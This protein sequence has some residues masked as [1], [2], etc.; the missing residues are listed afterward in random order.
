MK[1]SILGGIRRTLNY[2]HFTLLKQLK[3]KLRPSPTQFSIGSCLTHLYGCKRYHHQNQLSQIPTR[4]EKK[5]KTTPL[6][7]HRHS[8]STPIPTPTP[9]QTFSS[10]SPVVI[11]PKVSHINTILLLLP[12]PSIPPTWPQIAR[13]WAPCGSGVFRQTFPSLIAEYPQW[14]PISRMSTSALLWARFSISTVSR[15]RQRTCSF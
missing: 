3:K 9:S 6:P 1:Q 10:L 5:L 14:R 8:N 4:K 2:H 11:L 13:F 7:N 15:T 12:T